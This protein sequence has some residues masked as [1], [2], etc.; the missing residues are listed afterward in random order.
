M[1]GVRGGDGGMREGEGGGGGGY[2]GGDGDDGRK[3]WCDG[4]KEWCDEAQGMWE[5]EIA[6]GF[7]SSFTLCDSASQR[8]RGGTQLKGRDTAKGAPPTNYDVTGNT[9]AVSYSCTT[10]PHTPSER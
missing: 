9:H 5:D 2:K 7:L 6:L 8:M 1:V 4:R 3:E 10:P